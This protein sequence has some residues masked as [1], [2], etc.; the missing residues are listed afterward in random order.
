[1]DGGSKASATPVYNYFVEQAKELKPTY[2]SMI[3]PARWYS[4]G[5]GLDAFRESMLHDHTELPLAFFTYIAGT[6]GS[7]INTQLNTIV[8]DTGVNG[9][10]MPVDIFINLAQD[11]AENGYDHQF[12]KNIF[13]VNREVRV[14]DIGR[15]TADYDSSQRGLSMIAESPA[16]YGADSN[17]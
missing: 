16:H 1:M 5:R 14:S 10:A 4:G 8:R 3:I 13:S 2:V 11:Y 15:S 7:N 12:L 17:G 9:S 6:F